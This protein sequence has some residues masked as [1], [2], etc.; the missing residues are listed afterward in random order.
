MSRIDSSFIQ[1][2][3]F[4]ISRW[5]VVRSRLTR[6]YL[7]FISLLTRV[8]DAAGAYYRLDEVSISVVDRL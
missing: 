6:V 3:I 2:G 1:T 4:A 8:R 5:G 7:A